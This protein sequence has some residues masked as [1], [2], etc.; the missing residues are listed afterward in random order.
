MIIGLSDRA[1]LVSIVDSTVVLT[2]INGVLLIIWNIKF[3]THVT[4]LDDILTYEVLD[5]TWVLTKHKR[6]G[7]FLNVHDSRMFGILVILDAQNFSLLIHELFIIDWRLFDW[8]VLLTLRIPTSFNDLSTVAGTN[9][10]S[11]STSASLLNFLL[12]FHNFNLT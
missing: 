4:I 5:L 8:A 6:V 9:R 10:T 1:S 11:T 2:L 7:F 3:L 12:T